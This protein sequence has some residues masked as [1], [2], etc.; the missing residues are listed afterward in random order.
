MIDQL[1]R[2]QQDDERERRRTILE[3]LQDGIGT[4][5]RGH[6]VEGIDRALEMRRRRRRRTVTDVALDEGERVMISEDKEKREENHRG[7]R[8]LR[9]RKGSER[10][11]IRIWGRTRD[12]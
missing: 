2:S 8:L 6:I 7:V 4:N 5:H 9:R 11:E 10:R 3:N 12:H 1:R